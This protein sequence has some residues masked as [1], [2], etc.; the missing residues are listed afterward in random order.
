MCGFCENIFFS[1]LIS[2]SHHVL[3]QNVAI[4]GTW[5]EWDDVMIAFLLVGLNNRGVYCTVD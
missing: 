5:S 3:L 2:D 1:A 4:V